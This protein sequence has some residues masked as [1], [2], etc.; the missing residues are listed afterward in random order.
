MTPK[1]LMRL[2]LEAGFDVRPRRDGPWDIWATEDSFNRLADLL[3]SDSMQQVALGQA[4]LDGLEAGRVARMRGALIA[5]LHD[6]QNSLALVND[7]LIL[8][9]LSRMEYEHKA[10]HI[11]SRLD[12]IK[13]ALGEDDDTANT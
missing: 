6:Y 12:M 1:E 4:Y 9:Q 2:A 8:S 11:K 13:F 5:V 10:S 7:L 3:A